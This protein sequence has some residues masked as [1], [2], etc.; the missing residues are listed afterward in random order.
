MEE[1]IQDETP[2]VFAVVDPGERSAARL[3]SYQ[4]TGWHQ[5]QLPTSQLIARTLSGFDE[6]IEQ[7]NVR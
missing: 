6:G 7:P 2:S 4:G 1:V 5:G 3:K